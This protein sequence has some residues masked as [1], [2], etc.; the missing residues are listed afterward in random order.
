MCEKVIQFGEGGFLRSFA[1]VFIHKMNEQGLFDGKVVVVQPIPTGLIPVLNE[2][3]GEYHQFLRGI[4]NGEVKSECIKVKSISRG[5]DP[6]TDYESYL[7]L[8]HQPE[9]RFIISNTTEAGI[10]YLGTES[11]SD[12]PPKSFPAKLT[13]LL[14]ERFKAGLGG[15]VILSCEL[16][17][18]NGK[19]LL[20]CVLKYA[21]LWNLGDDFITWLKTENHF[22]STLV[23]RICTGYPKDEAEALCAQIGESDKLLNTAELFQLWV[24]EGDFEDEFPLKKAGINVIWTNDVSPYK[25]MKVRILNGAH[26]SLVFPSLLCGIE[27]VGESLGDGDMRQFLDTCLNKYIMPTLGETDEHKAFANAVLERFA[28]PYIKHLWK[29]ISLN[30]VSKYTARVLPTVLDY[31]KKENSL[32]KPLVFSLACLI[33][34]YKTC[35]PTDSEDAVSFIKENDVSAILANTNLW[36]EDLSMMNDLVLACLDKLHADGI[37][38]ALKWATC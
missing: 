4:D 28:N 8:A 6:Y 14:Y 25:K 21:E 12:A 35:D 27:T 32:P 15:F 37:R 24:I 26:T 1:D 31:V 9:M 29:S 2:Q 30:S 16:I 5:V 38:E 7:A 20:E 18:N 19:K 34:Y 13:A 11:L 3:N 33:E 22:L 10:E 36:G 23:D 17:D